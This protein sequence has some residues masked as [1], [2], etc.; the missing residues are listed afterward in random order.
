VGASVQCEKNDKAQKQK[1]IGGTNQSSSRRR[2]ATPGNVCV[3]E[4]VGQFFGSKV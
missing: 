3:P 2:E 4:G 1:T